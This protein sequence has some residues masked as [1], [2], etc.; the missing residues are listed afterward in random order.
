M[1]P[2]SP[3]QSN[4]A[5]GRAAR[6]PAADGRSAT[7]GD[8]AATA[9]ARRG[10]RFRRFYTTAGIDPFDTVEWELRDALIT[11]ERGEKV[12]EQRGVEF[13]KSWSQTATNVVVSKYFRG[14]LGSPDRERSVRQ[15]IG[16]VADTLAAW[17]RRGGYF[18][19]EE[20]A[21]AFH[22]ELKHVLLYQHACFNSPVWFNVGIEERPQCSACFINSVEDTMA[23][24]LDLA[25]TEGMLFKFGSG[26]G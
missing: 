17:G 4:A 16:R 11:N 20:D 7:Q 10:L 6:K 12:F 2:Q 8:P 25:K 13:P 26:T 21:Q 3:L 5:R 9:P 23:S 15:L 22:A 19:A 1:E 18:A 14:H 24:I